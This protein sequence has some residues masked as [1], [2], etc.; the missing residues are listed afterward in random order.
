MALESGAPMSECTGSGGAC[1]SYEGPQFGPVWIEEPCEKCGKF[2][3]RE[4][5]W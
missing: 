4:D 3:M 5:E 2:H 1:Y